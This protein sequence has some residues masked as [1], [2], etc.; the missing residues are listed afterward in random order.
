MARVA[1]SLRRVRPDDDPAAF[2]E[3]DRV[4]HEIQRHLLQAQGVAGQ[5]VG[6]KEHALGAARGL[7]G[8]ARLG[9]LGGAREHQFLEVKA[10]L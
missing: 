2:G 10:V 4:A 6:R 5:Q 1:S 9:Q 8:V 3:L 7:G